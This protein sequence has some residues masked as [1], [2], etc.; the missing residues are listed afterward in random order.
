MIQD[1]LP[2]Y[3]TTAD[4]STTAFTTP[5]PL[6]DANAVSVYL[7]SD[8]AVSSAYSINLPT[9]TITFEIAPE[10]GTVVT[11]V[12]ALPISWQD[13]LNGSLDK[14]SL[15]EILTLVI[16][17]MQTLEEGLSRAPKTQ[18]YEEDTGT[19]LS[20]LF[21]QKI[22]AALDSLTQAQVIYG[23]IQ[24]AG[25]QALSD[26]STEKTTAISN[27]NS[28]ASDR[29]GEF[30]QNASTKTTAFNTN[31]NNVTD[32]FNAN[33]TA[34]T[35]AFNTNATNKTSDF[36]TN[37]TAKTTAFN[38]NATNKTSDFDTNAATKQAAVDASAS[39]AATSATNAATSATNAGASETAAATSAAN[40]LA[41]ETRIN[42]TLSSFVTYTSWGSGVI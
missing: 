35:T 37:A 15:G 7:D 4:G 27:I 33:A 39:A 13:Q 42:N 20:A 34:K 21:F 5:F 2:R 18:P 14:N 19:D 38:T 22:E 23:Q 11:I 40:A 1:I 8:L 6:I 10:A 16:A 28:T 36:D 12:R 3:Q 24:A 17:K 32:T 29:T 41:T 30:N 9:N 25:S 31:A 26:I